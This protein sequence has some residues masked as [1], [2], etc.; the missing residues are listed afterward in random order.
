MNTVEHHF[1][2]LASEYEVWKKRAWYYHAAVKSLLQEF[3]PPGKR[4]LELGCG[5]GA[6]LESLRPSAGVGVDVSSAMI[7]EARRLRPQFTFS[8]GRAEKLEL[9]RPVDFVVMVD[10]VEHI[11]DLEAAFRGLAHAVS[12]QTLIISTSANPLWAPILHLAERLKLKM[13][14]GPH[15]WPNL[16]ELR[17]LCQRTGFEIETIAHRM[18][19]PISIPGISD[20]LN[21]VYPR[22]GFLARFCLIQAVAFRRQA[23]T[24]NGVMTNIK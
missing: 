22:Q 8:V 9:P 2:S 11:P 19:M 13:P 10:L 4:V 14:E 21:R 1:D 3:V 7:E 12:S 5:T 23:S 24:E 15:R 17:D 20:F 16:N 6:I 18:I